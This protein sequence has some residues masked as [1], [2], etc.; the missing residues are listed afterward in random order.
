MKTSLLSSLKLTARPEKTAQSPLLKRRERLLV[1]LE[2]QKDM[3]QALVNGERYIAYKDKWQINPETKAKELIQEPIKIKPWFYQSK[4]RYFFEVRYA[5]KA[6][7]LQAGK[8]AI[9]VGSIDN[10]VT[11]IET[12]IQAVIAGELDTLLSAN[13]PFSKKVAKDQEAPV[14]QGEAK[15]ESEAK[16]DKQTEPMSKNPDKSSSKST[17]KTA[18]KKTSS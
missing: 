4:N 16:T 7:A 3:A 18:N 11:T 17:S 13:N 12:V 1:K 9:E 2:R 10:L 8:Q 6:L 15:L 14:N 5:N